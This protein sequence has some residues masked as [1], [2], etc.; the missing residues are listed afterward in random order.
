MTRVEVSRGISAHPGCILRV[1]ERQDILERPEITQNLQWSYDVCQKHVSSLV[2]ATR[3][4]K[5]SD[6][7]E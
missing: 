4:A 3:R 5:P 6:P 2:R 7:E 1:R